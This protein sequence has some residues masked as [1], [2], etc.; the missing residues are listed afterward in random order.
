M[1][2]TKILLSTFG[3]AALALSFSACGQ[4]AA[5]TNTTANAVNQS[6]TANVVNSAKQT[7]APTSDAKT[8][9]TSASVCDVSAYITDKDPKGLNVRDSSSENGKVIG[10]IPFDKEAPIVH[11]ISSSSNGW[12]M[13]DK[14]TVFDFKADADKV[15]FDNKGWVSANLLAI[16]ARGYDTG[17]VQLYE[18]GKGSKVL[19]KIPEDTVMKIV[20]CDGKRMQVKYKNFTGWLEPDAQCVSASGRCN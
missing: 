16:S 20:G 17:G 7:N 12:M 5:V 2:L 8:S 6:N 14:A 11:I 18:G 10:Q 3:G 1:K 15:I 9:A 4:N 19:T 13:V